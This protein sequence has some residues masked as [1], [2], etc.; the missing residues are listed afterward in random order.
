MAAGNDVM[1]SMFYK[2]ISSDKIIKSQQRDEPD[3]TREEKLLIL[4][5][6]LETNPGTFLMRFGSVLDED[7]L[8]YFDDSDMY[9]V[10]YRLKELRKLQGTRFISGRLRNRRYR[11][12]KVLSNTTDY[13]DI[14][15][16]KERYPELF[17][18]YI[19]QYL[20]EEE[21]KLMEQD[22]MDKITSLTHLLQRASNS[23][24]DLKIKGDR[25]MK[26]SDNPLEA[27]ED[28]EML[29]KEFIQA[30]HVSFINGE[31][32]EFDYTTVDGNPEY[33]DMDIINIDHEDNYF[34]SEEP[35]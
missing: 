12:I 11:A 19:G 17:E 10:Q 27:E 2:I 8:T 5:D 6:I 24:D 16:M 14:G 28:K 33:D 3:L 35:S 21:R 13:F 25:G 34:D 9:E 20:T 15:P 31:D 30:V 7:H 22:E 1:M 29:R 18:Y 4:G 32:G 26:L 23:N